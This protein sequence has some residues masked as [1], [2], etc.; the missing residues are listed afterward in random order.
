MASSYMYSVG[1]RE[2]RSGWD[3]EGAV[4]ILRT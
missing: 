2:W 1:E 3:C 4:Y